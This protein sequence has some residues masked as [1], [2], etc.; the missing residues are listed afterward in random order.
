MKEEY[1]HQAAI[2]AND[3]TLTDKGVF[4]KVQS[5]QVKTANKAFGEHYL[6]SMEQTTTPNPRGKPEASGANVT[7]LP[8]GPVC[9]YCKW[10]GHVKAECRA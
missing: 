3:Y 10:R 4:K 6:V 9:F 5:G 2:W 7:S 1:L 8:P